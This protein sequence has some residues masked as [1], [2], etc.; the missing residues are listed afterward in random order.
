MFIPGFPVESRIV[1]IQRLQTFYLQVR[2][3][4]ISGTRIIANKPISVFSGHECEDVP[5][6]S[7]PC[8]MLIEQIAP[9]DTWGNE[10]VTIPLRAR[11]ANVIKVF[12]LHD[13][14]TVSVTCTNISSGIVTND[15]S[16]TLDCNQFMELVIN[17]YI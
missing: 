12:A 6:S 14:T 13:S 10:V 2:G 3:G 4:D 1:T 7:E 5:L 8:D 15:S 9:I 16:F 17:D 11:S